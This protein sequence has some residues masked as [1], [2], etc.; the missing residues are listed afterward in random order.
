MR[1]FLWIAVLALTG[2][3]AAPVAT[4]AQ[5]DAPFALNSTVPEAAS[6]LS[7]TPENAMEQLVTLAKLQGDVIFESRRQDSLSGGEIISRT[8]GNGTAQVYTMPD[9]QLWQARVMAGWGDLC[10]KQLT[11]DAT[12]AQFVSTFSPGAPVSDGKFVATLTAALKEKRIEHASYDGTQFS[13]S[14]GCVSSLNVKKE[15]AIPS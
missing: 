4:S 6:R 8:Y 9:G 15:G 14:G 1:S 3:E 12:I 5:A 13:A 7:L 11:N 2:C 10:G